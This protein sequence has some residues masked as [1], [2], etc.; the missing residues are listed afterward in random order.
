MVDEPIMTHS[1][2]W[3]GD[4]PP[5]RPPRKPATTVQAIIMLAA[6]VFTIT[7]APRALYYGFRTRSIRVPFDKWHHTVNVEHHV[8]FAACVIGWSLG[9][10]LTSLL[11]LGAAKQLLLKVTR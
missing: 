1:E 4:S 10:L 3:T 8:A 2:S 7:Y 9:L 6:S 11:G 5:K